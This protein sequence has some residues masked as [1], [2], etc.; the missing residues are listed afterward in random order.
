MTVWTNDGMSAAAATTQFDAALDLDLAALLTDAAVA[1][2]A[3]PADAPQSDIAVLVAQLPILR[4]SSGCEA[5][6]A[7]LRG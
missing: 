2:V 3:R 7:A 4:S 5:F 1:K 6:A